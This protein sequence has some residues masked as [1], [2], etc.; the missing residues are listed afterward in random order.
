MA[1]DL[2]PT[3]ILLAIVA[4]VAIV[5]IVVMVTSSVSQGQGYSTTPVLV[6]TLDEN[7]TVVGQAYTWYFWPDEG[8]SR[9]G[10]SSSRV[11][12]ACTC[13][14]LYTGYPS[15]RTVW[16]DTGVRCR[17]GSQCRATVMGQGR[18]IGLGQCY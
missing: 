4:I 14:V 3:L 2:K 15:G 11:S 10:P 7:G 16:L 5:G 1:E 13:H 17:C 12:P 9:R 6:E 8:Q 18:A